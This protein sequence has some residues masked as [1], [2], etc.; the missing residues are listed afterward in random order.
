MIKTKE[1]V[2]VL[3]KHYNVN[4]KLGL[5]Y[6]QLAYLVETK[7]KM[8]HAGK[9]L[10]NLSVDKTGIHKDKMLAYFVNADV[11][12]TSDIAFEANDSQFKTVLD[13]FQAV[14]KN[15]QA[16]RVELQEAAAATLKAND[17]ESFEFLQWFIKDGVKDSSEVAAVIDIIESCGANNSLADHLISEVEEE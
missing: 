17:Y 12:L 7:F 3:N 10:M 5:E 1:V 14:L 4:F 13:V 6:A 8:P 9:F 15:E 11:P 16:V 2:S